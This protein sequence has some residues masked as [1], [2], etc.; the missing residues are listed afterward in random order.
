MKWFTSSLVRVQS[1]HQQDKQSWVQ[2]T[3]PSFQRSRRLPGVETNWL[4]L[5]RVCQLGTPSNTSSLMSKTERS[6]STIAV[7]H[8][9]R[10]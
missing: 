10:V 7:W 4:S 8:G 3:L 2:E 9:L 6:A 5:F 1:K